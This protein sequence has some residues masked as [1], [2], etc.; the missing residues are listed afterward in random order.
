MGDGWVAVSSGQE[1]E[2]LSDHRYKSYAGRVCK[3]FGGL[4]CLLLTSHRQCCDELRDAGAIGV[5]LAKSDGPVLG[6]DQVFDWPNLEYS[7]LGYGRVADEIGD[8]TN[9]ESL[10]DRMN[11]RS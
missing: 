8:D 10:F 1:F 2:E 9:S 6:R 4:Y 7:F 5:E 3:F 11:D